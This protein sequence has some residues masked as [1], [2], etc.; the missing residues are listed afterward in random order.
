METEIEG[1]F[2]G[3]ESHSAIITELFTFFVSE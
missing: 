3:K 1:S 2:V